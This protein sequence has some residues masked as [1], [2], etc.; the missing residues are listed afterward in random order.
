MLLLDYFK[1]L[2]FFKSDACYSMTGGQ[3]KLIKIAPRI[4]RC[5]MSETH[6]SGAPSREG[7]GTSA[8]PHGSRA[9]LGS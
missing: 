8:P 1:I 5:P 2:C 9:V 7:V 6:P 3:S 4:P